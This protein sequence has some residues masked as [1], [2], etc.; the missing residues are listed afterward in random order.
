MGLVPRAAGAAIAAPKDAADE[1]DEK[2]HHED[3][4]EDESSSFG[5]GVEIAALFALVRPRISIVVKAASVLVVPLAVALWRVGGAMHGWS[6]CGGVDGRAAGGRAALALY[7]VIGG[8]SCHPCRATRAGATLDV[9]ASPAVVI[10]IWV[11]A[12]AILEAALGFSSQCRRWRN[13]RWRHRRWRWWRPCPRRRVDDESH[14][15]Q[16]PQNRHWKRLGA[17]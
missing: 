13:R 17:L 3:N 6:V 11:R 8:V 7:L 16:V 2:K 14:E 5:T 4:A 9:R 10:T 12:R 15:G 1:A